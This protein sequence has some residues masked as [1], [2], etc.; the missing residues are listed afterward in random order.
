M[1]RSIMRYRK[2]PI[3]CIRK[4]FSAMGLPMREYTPNDDE[5]LE[6]YCYYTVISKIT[7]RVSYRSINM[8]VYVFGWLVGW[9]IVIA[10]WQ[11]QFLPA[12]V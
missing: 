7:F 2:S 8:D 6:I 1:I 4:R 10:H 9:L 3:G 5:I 11:L 12:S